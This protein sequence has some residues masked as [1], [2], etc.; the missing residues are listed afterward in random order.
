ME[1]RQVTITFRIRSRDFEQ[2]GPALERALTQAAEQA[3]SAFAAAS[4]A[5]G[6][7][8]AN[9]VGVPEVNYIVH[10]HEGHPLEGAD[11]EHVHDGPHQHPRQGLG[12]IR[13]QGN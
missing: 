10:E 6:P 1:E 12:A 4:F 7:W 5:P 11:H 9:T 8:S 13:V 3:Q 2:R